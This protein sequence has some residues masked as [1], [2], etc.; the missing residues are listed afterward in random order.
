MH[1]P[2][3]LGG[4]RLRRPGVGLST[5]TPLSLLLPRPLPFLGTL[6]APHPPAR[7]AGNAKSP[8]GVCRLLSALRR[9]PRCQSQ[10]G[11]NQSFM[12]NYCSVIRTRGRNSVI[13]CRLTARF[14]AHLCG[15]TMAESLQEERSVA[16]HAGTKEL[17]CVYGEPPTLVCPAW[18]RSSAL[19]GRGGRPMA[20]LRGGR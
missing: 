11:R 18:R 19:A 10:H 15:D 2:R 6:G 16:R 13:T 12:S 20:G 7:R 14:R 8:E 5:D 9:S 3:C 1:S 17:S 4:H